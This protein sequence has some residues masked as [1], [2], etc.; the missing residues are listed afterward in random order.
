MFWRQIPVNLSSN[1]ETK[2]VISNEHFEDVDTKHLQVASF[3][4]THPLVT[5]EQN[6]AMHDYETKTKESFD[7]I[8]SVVK[9][10]LSQLHKQGF[11]QWANEQFY[12]K[13][14]I[15]LDKQDLQFKAYSP[16]VFQDVYAKAVFKQFFKLSE[17]FFLKDP[18][19]GQQRSEV[20]M[21]LK[22][23]GIHAAGISPCSDGRLAHFVSYVLRLPY[24][25]IRRK[26]HAGS[27]FDVSESVR[28]WVFVEHSR[29]RDGVPN[30][31]SEPTRYLK[32]GVYHFSQQDPLKQG[33]A[34]HGSNEE[35]AAQATLLKLNDFKQAIENRF[36]SNAKVE[37]LLFGINTD[38]DALKVHVPDVN[39]QASL[40]RYIES[41]VLFDLT[42]PLDQTAARAKVIAEIDECNRSQNV[43]LPREPIRDLLAWFITNNF[44]QLD[45]VNRYEEGCYTDIGHAER[46]IGVGN[47]FEE[48][49]L[50]NLTYYA[51]LDTVEEGVKDV[52]VGIKIFK[53]LNIKKGLPIPVI[54]RCDY[55]GRV[56]GSYA[57]AKQ[58]A[59]RIEAAIHKRY[60]DISECGL[61]KTLTTLRDKI[62]NKPAEQVS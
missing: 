40:L 43:S 21:K 26:A 13:L 19:N 10:V 34:A 5:I 15:R 16:Q 39:G 30:A 41:S 14:G 20:E 62:G 4:D 61:L 12:S 25:S 36:G 17:N 51:F 44:S 22:Q 6:R 53:S 58:K 3:N 46:F 8:E 37:T 60:K 35:K 32:I 38:N 7:L 52:D 54:V 18:L 31:A 2:N 24:S 47:G 49:Q 33:C 28:N 9:E 27:L 42:K 57:R 1:I 23:A 45:Y 55:D 48:V 56:P 59:L 50:R 29:F 11:V